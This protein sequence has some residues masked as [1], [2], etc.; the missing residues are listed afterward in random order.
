MKNLEED[1]EEK[2]AYI[3]KEIL[4]KGYEPQE[5]FFYL[6]NFK[7]DGQNL[8]NW[9]LDELKEAIQEF[10]DF[11]LAQKLQDE[12]ENDKN[13]PSRLLFG[14]GLEQ[15][16]RQTPQGQPIISNK[17]LPK[18]MPLLNQYQPGSY[19]EVTQ[20]KPSIINKNSKR[21]R[22]RCVG[23]KVNQVTEFLFIKSNQ[24]Q[25]NIQ[26]YPMKWDVVRI[27]SDVY[28]LRKLLQLQ[29][30]HL[31]IAPLPARQEYKFTKKSI[32]K[33]LKY[34]ER[35]F[36]SLCR[37]EQL[38]TYQILVE[39]L[40]IKHNNSKTFQEKMKA[41]EQL[42]TKQRQYL[43]PEVE[44]LSS[45]YGKVQTQLHPLAAS[46]SLPVFI[47]S[48]ETILQ[49]L[50]I[51]GQELKEKSDVL[52][53][54]FLKFQEILVKISQNHGDVCLPQLEIFAYLSKVFGTEGF[55]LSQQGD[56]IQEALKYLKFN[57]QYMPEL[58]EI[59]QKSEYSVQKFKKA[60]KNFL[61]KRE[62]V[63]QQLGQDNQSQVSKELID[64]L[65]PVETKELEKSAQFMNY[66]T[67]Q[68][69]QEAKRMQF[70]M[71]Y[72]GMKDN[73]RDLAK[74]IVVGLNQRNIQWSGII[75]SL[76][77]IEFENI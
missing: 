22:V 59:Q 26:T 30:P 60:E 72:E 28:L 29:F 19:L 62:K 49:N 47:E 71:E 33:R 53:A 17:Q 38:C 3:D 45:F 20:L 68:I 32:A 61:T 42:L 6:R 11:Q 41:E 75:N 63:I 77:K 23:N 66:F 14:S 18:I 1:K 64:R 4:E 21:I 34:F 54:S 10:H 37:S 25:F 58:K 76:E 65:L 70:E 73:F 48:Y 13:N 67:N 7:N 40:M 2:Q 35:F 74:K 39:F 15:N 27:E 43:K 69:F 24:L 16:P 57:L 55:V 52:C 56:T 44:H 5:F 12:E 46:F 51:L 31:L 36:D 50:F 8:D 9:S